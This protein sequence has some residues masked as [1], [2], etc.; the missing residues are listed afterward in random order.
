MMENVTALKE[1]Y[2]FGFLVR[3]LERIGYQIDYDVVDVADYGVPQ[4]R[5]RLVMVGS[6][7]GEIKI[8]PRTKERKTVRDAIGKLPSIR[9]TGDPLH[10]IVA[11]HSDKV[12]E[13]IKQIPC[14]GGS[15]SDLPIKYRL[16]CHENDNVGFKDIYG[17]LHWNDVSSTITGGC[18]NPSKGRFLHPAKNRVIT[19]REAALLQTFP[20]KYRFPMDIPKGKLAVLIG[21]A[22]PPKF[23]RIQARH[24]IKHLSKSHG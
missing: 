15:R 17:R 22:L 14:N 21:N 5:K 9:K 24:L 1:Y 11:D 16:K 3:S 12:M 2:L 20:A 4:R 8:A 6:L 10:R 7:L 19:P 23:S 18:L 13:M